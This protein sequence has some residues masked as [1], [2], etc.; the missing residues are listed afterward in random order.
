M[1]QAKKNHPSVWKFI[2]A[3]RKRDRRAAWVSYQEARLDGLAAE[4]LFWDMFWP[5]AG[6]PV[7]RA[8]VELYHDSRRGLCDF[9]IGLERLVLNL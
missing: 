5:V 3:V 2:A 9:E 6:T 8:L 4:A 7:G 1:P